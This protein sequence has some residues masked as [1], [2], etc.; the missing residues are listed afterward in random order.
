MHGANLALQCRSGWN[1]LLKSVITVGPSTR[2][3]RTVS[4]VTT[5]VNYLRRCIAASGQCTEGILRFSGTM[6]CIC[7]IIPSQMMK[8]VLRERH[9]GVYIRVKGRRFW[10]PCSLS[11]SFQFFSP[12]QISLAQIRAFPSC[13]VTVRDGQWVDVL[14][15]SLTLSVVVLPRCYLQHRTLNCSSTFFSHYLLILR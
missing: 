15:Q 9:G 2:L 8:A 14:Q 3:E 13:C 11:V 10:V 5:A 6:Q 12:G 1:I 7:R 4:S